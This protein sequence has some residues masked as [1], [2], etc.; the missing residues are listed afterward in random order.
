MSEGFLPSYPNEAPVPRKSSLASSS[1][2][3]GICSFLFGIVAG[4]PA[5]VQGCRALRQIHR[6]QGGLYGSGLALGGISLGVIGS[7]VSTGFIMFAINRLQETA[8][9]MH[10]SLSQ[11]ALAM[12]SYHDVHGKLPPAVVYG[13]GGQA[14]Y[15]WRVLLLPYVEE[16]DLYHEFRLDEAWD[17]AHNRGLLKR[18]PFIY[19]PRRK[20]AANAPYCTCIKTMTGK[21]AVFEGKYGRRIQ[22][23]TDGVSITILLVETLEPVLWSKPEDVAYAPDQPLPRLGGLFRDG[24]RAAFADGH[25]SFLPNDLPETTLRGMITRNGGERIGYNIP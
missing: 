25:T 16:G 12:H 8:D 24:F 20:V 15:S 3:F 13:K 17:S 14:L 18:M 2:G 19:R 4:L 7:V 10:R 6:P 5:I 11:L 23:I 21:G 9:R 1:L 22:D